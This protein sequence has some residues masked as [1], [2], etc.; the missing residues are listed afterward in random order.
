MYKKVSCCHSVLTD[1]F[2]FDVKNRRECMYNIAELS[3]CS[4]DCGYVLVRRWRSLHPPTALP[5]FKRSISFLQRSGKVLIG[6]LTRF[7][8][9]TSYTAAT[10]FKRFVVASAFHNIRFIGH[11][12]CNDSHFIQLRTYCTSSQNV[13]LT[14]HVRFLRRKVMWTIDDLNLATEI[15]E[16]R[17][18]VFSET[19]HDVFRDQFSVELGVLVCPALSGQVVFKAFGA[20]FDVRQVD[21]WKTEGVDA[22]FV[23]RE[24]SKI[25]S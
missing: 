5:V 20:F 25:F 24:R 14:P 23:P 22:H 17:R 8:S 15:S 1:S 6:S 4:H 16:T 7:A 3:L 21:I 11:S 18:N 2:A 13:E 10:A 19:I 12:P 9:R